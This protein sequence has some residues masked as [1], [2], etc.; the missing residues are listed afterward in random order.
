MYKLLIISAYHADSHAYWLSQL[1]QYLSQSCDFELEV[2]HLPARFFAW[3]VGGNALSLLSEYSDVLAGDYDVLLATSMCDI[4]SLKALCPSLAQVPS[5]LYFHENQFEY[6]KSEYN[7]EAQRLRDESNRLNAQMRSIH[8]VLAADKV[9]FNSSFN[10]SSFLQGATALLE[11]MPDLKPDLLT[12]VEP[13]LQVLPVPL[14]RVEESRSGLSVWQQSK[15]NK[16]R[17]LWCARWEFDK[18]LDELLAIADGIKHRQND[19]R[20]PEIEWVILGQ[21]FRQV[22]KAMKAFLACHEAS[23]LHA[24]FIE[25]KADFLDC[26]ASC[27]VVLSTTLHEFFGIAVMEAV[28]RG[29]LPVLPNRQVYPELYGD[30][31]LYNT[32]DEAI[33]MLSDYAQEKF[34]GA[35][36]TEKNGAHQSKPDIE[37]VLSQ[38]LAAQSSRL[39]Q[40]GHLD[41]A[42]QHDEVLQRYKTVL[43]ELAQQ[44]KMRALGIHLEQ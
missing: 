27:D 32:I 1:E 38:A 5:L 12:L 23:I 7:S 37:T 20:T 6:P 19:G 4:A 33:N 42:Y 22:P 18:G 28:E 41:L 13:K 25:E 39:N 17:I 9:A 15:S 2:I 10:Q 31:Y 26:I 44:S 30:K 14:A 8:G 34:Q 3:R 43:S 35:N 29:C 21:K 40:G 36:T 24:G 11:K 16:L